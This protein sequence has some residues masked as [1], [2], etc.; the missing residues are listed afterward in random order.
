MEILLALCLALLFTLHVRRILRERRLAQ[1]LT[2]SITARRLHLAEDTEAHTF[3][4]PWQQLVAASNQI[5]EEARLASAFREAHLARIRALIDAFR[6]SVIIT[7][8][9][10][11]ILL[12]NEAARTLF[13]PELDIVGRR[14]PRLI[15]STDLVTFIDNIRRGQASRPAEMELL[16][17]GK[18][19]SLTLGG[20]LLPGE[21]TSTAPGRW[22]LFILT[23][24]TRER[25]LEGI[26]RD[27]VGNVSHELRTP[28]S[29]IRGYSETLADDH[30]QMPVEDRTRFIQAIHRHSLRLASLVEDLLTLSRLDSKYPGFEYES[31]DVHSVINTLAEDFLARARATSHEVVLELDASEHLVRADAF[32]LTQ[33][34]ENLVE[35]ALK[36][37]GTGAR[38][39]IATRV[40]S[41]SLVIGVVDNG[42][43]IPAKDLPRIFERFYRV[44]K[45]R[46][47][48]K[49]GTGLGLTIVRE[50]VELHGGRVWV[51]SEEGRGTAFW[52]SLPLLVPTGPTS[53]RD[54]AGGGAAHS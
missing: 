23:D 21:P 41:G 19:R 28:I 22:M 24:V 1:A 54:P 46:S 16:L 34:L 45:G 52:F 43:G 11:Q 26:Q 48:D 49:G 50:I 17:E 10:A 47:R 32:R 6:E 40:S 36:Y 7:D 4:G 25:Q 42:Q 44:E 39:R 31:V 18:P 2:D 12:A 5:I 38:I 35:N 14:L 33:V 20:A 37:S 15:P 30:Q 29:V 27:L 8:E 51:E 9:S 13:S 3:R 53:S